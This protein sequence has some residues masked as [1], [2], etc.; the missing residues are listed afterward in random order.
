MDYGGE[1]VLD[2]GFYTIDILYK[3]VDIQ[4][5]K[6]ESSRAYALWRGRGCYT[7]V[8]YRQ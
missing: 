7:S 3:K 6:L 1:K 5:R 2:C 4:Y 8:I